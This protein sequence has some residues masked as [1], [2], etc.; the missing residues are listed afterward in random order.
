MTSSR[1]YLV[2]VMG[3]FEYILEIPREASVVVGG[4][5]GVCSNWFIRSV[6][7]RYVE[8]VRE[9]GEVVKFVGEGF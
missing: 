4:V 2:S 1:I 9:W 6:E 8:R 5:I 7:F 3:M